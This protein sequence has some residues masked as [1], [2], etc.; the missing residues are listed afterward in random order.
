MGI[1]EGGGE[2]MVLHAS[3]PPRHSPA[4]PLTVHVVEQDV[5]REEA[6][7]VARRDVLERARLDVDAP[8]RRLE[9]RKVLRLQ[10]ARAAL[11]RVRAEEVAVV[12]VV[13]A[14]D[15]R[16]V[17]E[18]VER[19]ED[20]VALEEVHLRRGGGGRATRHA[21]GAQQQQPARRA[22]GSTALR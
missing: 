13:V 11:G 17:E 6:V 22:P 14:R 2:A 8:H 15:V 1:P 5:A 21:G 19:V 9:R 12:E 7:G 10:V 16:V 18:V 3:P 4:A 20:N